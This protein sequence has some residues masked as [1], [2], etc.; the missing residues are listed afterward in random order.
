ML[1]QL[2]LRTLIAFVTIVGV[3]VMSFVGGRNDLR[4]IDDIRAGGRAAPAEIVE[5]G[6]F[7]T[8]SGVRN[9]W[10]TVAW[11]DAYGM[12]R[13]AERVRVSEDFARSHGQ[14]ARV[15]IRYLPNRPSD[16]PLID[17]D[18]EFAAKL[19]ATTY[20]TGHIIIALVVIGA[21]YAAAM[22]AAFR[23]MRLHH[24]MVA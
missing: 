13:A 21:L 10:V 8:K 7:R 3:G 18:E 4:R 14:H 20:Q 9:W 17:D 1:S 16:G 22:F 11:R 2:Q 24:G 15:G 23:T 19:A 5:V 6:Y 12:A